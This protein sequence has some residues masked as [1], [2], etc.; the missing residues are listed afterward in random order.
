MCGAKAQR[1][2]FLFDKMLMIAKKKDGGALSF[3][4]H[5]MVGFRLK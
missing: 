3:K 2:V 1:H 4:G 5:I